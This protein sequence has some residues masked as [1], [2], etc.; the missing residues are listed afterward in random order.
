[1]KLKYVPR[2]AALLLTIWAFSI[3]LS[4]TAHADLMCGPLGLGWGVV[5][6][7]MTCDEASDVQYE[8]RSHPMEPQFSLNDGTLIRCQTISSGNWA[9]CHDGP[10]WVG[11][12]L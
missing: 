8:L 10:G 2:L 7:P 1:V 3:P 4:P 12:K 9:V 11:F 5:H 6:E